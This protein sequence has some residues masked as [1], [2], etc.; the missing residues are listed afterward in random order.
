MGLKIAVMSN[1]VL[2]GR[3]VAYGQ[4]STWSNSRYRY[5]SDTGD[6]RRGRILPAAPSG[7]QTDDGTLQAT[8]KLARPIP[9]D[10]TR[11]AAA[12]PDVGE[13]ASADRH[14]VRNQRRTQ[15]SETLGECELR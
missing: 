14:G 7:R 6:L 4:F 1:V 10:A 3:R 5:N 15:H 12:A 11:S 9:I 13:K 2:L 8:D